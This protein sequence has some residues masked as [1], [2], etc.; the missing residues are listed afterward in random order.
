M[1]SR[2]SEKDGPLVM[3]SGRI[4]KEGSQLAFWHFAL[5]SIVPWFLP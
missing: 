3:F 2:I 1:N 5:N 4:G